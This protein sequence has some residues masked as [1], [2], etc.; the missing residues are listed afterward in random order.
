MRTLRTL[1]PKASKGNLG[2]RALPSLAEAACA[3]REAFLIESDGAELPFWDW[4]RAEALQNCL[5]RLGGRCYCIKCLQSKLSISHLRVRCSPGGDT[6]LLE[7]VMR[8]DGRRD[9]MSINRSFAVAAATG[10]P[11]CPGAIG[12]NNWLQKP[13]NQILKI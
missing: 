12:L 7:V 10:G 4:R 1:D 9:W 11:N 3:E 13:L 6:F 2:R 8:V 5:H